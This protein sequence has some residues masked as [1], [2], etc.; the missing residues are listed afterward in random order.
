[1]ISRILPSSRLGAAALVLA[2]QL[3]TGCRSLM[4]SGN[5]PLKEENEDADEEF[6]A[7]D[8]NDTG[9]TPGATG[10]AGAKPKKLVGPK[11]MGFEY[12]ARYSY[13]VI[14]GTY[15]DEQ[16]NRSIRRSKTLEDVK[17]VGARYQV[18]S[19]PTLFRSSGGAHHALLLLELR[20]ERPAPEYWT[21]RTIGILALGYVL[22]MARII[23]PVIG[24]N[25]EYNKIDLEHPD[26]PEVAKSDVRAHILGVRARQKI[27]GSG[28]WL[29]FSYDLNLHML[30]FT[31]PNNGYE[32]E[33]G[34]SSALQWQFVRVDLGAS[35][36]YQRYKARRE[37]GQGFREKVVVDSTYN[38]L[39]FT[40]TFWL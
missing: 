39:I 25:A 10:K 35:Y 32:A 38:A 33:A 28:R 7:D 17:L 30:N 16:E 19:Y 15:G 24:I 40:G 18:E 31:L 37:A 23:A 6:G 1:M 11:I 5:Q 4:D 13:G 27:W 26:G 14:R 34:L 20:R 8:L 22:P 3:A 12:L 36:L 9:G 2:L 21:Q 29:A